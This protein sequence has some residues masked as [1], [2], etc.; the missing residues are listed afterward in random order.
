VRQYFYQFL[1][2]VAFKTGFGVILAH[3][4]CLKTKNYKIPRTFNKPYQ[5]LLWSTSLEGL[6]ELH[7]QF[8]KS[9]RKYLYAQKLISA[10]SIIRNFKDLQWFLTCYLFLKLIFDFI[11]QFHFI[12]CGHIFMK[13]AQ[14]NNQNI[15]L[16]IEN[17]A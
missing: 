16:K 7:N 13:M 3:L 14:T 8:K 9:K 11:G 12:C 15:A 5:G 4:A 2:T 17:C 10:N 1:P 6:V